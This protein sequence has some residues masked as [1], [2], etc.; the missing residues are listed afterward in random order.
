MR[1]NVQIW[2]L[3]NKT[4]T[5]QLNRQCQKNYQAG[6][7]HKIRKKKKALLSRPVFSLKI[8]INLSVLDYDL[9]IFCNPM[10]VYFKYSL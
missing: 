4:E 10:T 1:S 6:N 7:L 9:T 5:K 8:K 3:R 2:S